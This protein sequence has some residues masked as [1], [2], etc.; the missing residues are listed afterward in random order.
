VALR[1]EAS[2]LHSDA[3]GYAA[4]K[5]RKDC[6]TPWHG[7]QRIFIWARHGRRLESLVRDCNAESD[8]DAKA[9]KR[10]SQTEDTD[11]LQ[12]RSAISSTR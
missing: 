9:S 3:T 10:S 12:P 2:Q 5:M 7:R 4:K 11:T 1:L 8:F 6:F